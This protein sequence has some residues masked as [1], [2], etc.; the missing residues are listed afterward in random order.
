M[1]IIGSGN[2]PLHKRNGPRADLCVWDEVGAGLGNGSIRIVF[3][4]VFIV[5]QVLLFCI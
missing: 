2:S 3:V 5:F 1:L 4:S